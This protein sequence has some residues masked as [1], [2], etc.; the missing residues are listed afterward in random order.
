[1]DATTI[2]A[3]VS[4]AIVFG[5]WLVLPHRAAPAVVDAKETPERVPVLEAV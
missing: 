4:C 2:M 5:G 3:M 1:M